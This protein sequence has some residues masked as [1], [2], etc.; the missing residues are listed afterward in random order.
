MR[1]AIS[2][3]I[4]DEGIFT[5]SCNALFALRMRLSMSAIGSVSIPCLLP[6]RLR[7]TRNHALVRQLA[8]ADPAEAELLE[9]GARAPAAVA[10]R[11]IPHLELLR[12]L[13]LHNERLPRHLLIPPVVAAERQ[14]ESLQQRTSVFVGLGGSR[15]RHVE[16]ADLLNVVGVDLRKDDLLARTERVV[17]AA[18]ERV[19]V[20]APEVADARE[21][22]RDEPVEELVHPRAAQRDLRADRHA[23]ADLELR[24]GL[25]RLA[26]LRAL[27]GDRRE[28]LHGGVELLGVVLR[29]ADAHVERDL[30]D[31][32]H[33]HDRLDLEVVLQLRTDL[34]VVALFEARRVYLGVGHLLVDLLAAIGVLA[35]ADAYRLVLD[36][37]Q[38]RADAGRSL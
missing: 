22:D 17:A 26:D 9:H 33:L 30:R 24:H 20:E 5:D 31:T 10:P 3:F 37:A 14:A 34:V 27:A 7:H 25:A 8:Q 28:L 35:V 1:R 21:R 4:F 15:D 18:V 29:L 23:L 12:L 19:R 11:V 38:V 16:P 13:L 36:R 2:T 6:A 32:R